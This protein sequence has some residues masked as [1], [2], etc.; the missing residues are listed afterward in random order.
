MTDEYATLR[1]SNFMRD[2]LDLVIPPSEDEK[3]PGA[4]TLGLSAD[5]A[6]AIIADARFAPLVEA[7]LQAVQDAA[8]VRDSAG[9]SE[10]SPE[11]RLEVVESQLMA[12]PALMNG[13]TSHLYLA[14]YQHPAVLEGLGEPA[15]PPFPEGFEVEETDPKLLDALRERARN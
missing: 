6:D 13:I 8:I 3:M 11:A 2:F 7:G 12:H 15:R 9:F 10:L 5:L 4:G 1:D 14:Y